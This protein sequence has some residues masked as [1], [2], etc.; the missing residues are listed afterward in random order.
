MK[1][2]GELKRFGVLFTCLWS[3]TIHLETATAVTTN[4]FI[5][6]I[7]RFHWLYRN[8]RVEHQG[9]GNILKKLR[10]STTGFLVVVLL[11]QT[12]SESPVPAVTLPIFCLSKRWQTS[13][14]T[15]TLD[16]QATKKR[17]K[18]IRRSFHLHAI[19]LYLPA[20][21][22]RL[23]SRLFYQRVKSLYRSSQTGIMLNEPRQSAWDWRIN[24][25]A[26]YE[27]SLQLKTAV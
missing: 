23:T 14:R 17:A 24:F 25:I 26:I 16:H 22:W 11:L 18:K 8:H 4:S 2:K 6:A 15:E 13:P 7:R 21:S 10:S 1:K 27:L 20:N 9:P 3:R 5:N 19:T 12:T